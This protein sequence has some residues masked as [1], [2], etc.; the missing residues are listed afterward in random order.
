MPPSDGAT[1]TEY[2]FGKGGKWKNKKYRK[3]GGITKSTQRIQ[4]YKKYKLGD[5]YRWKATFA[6]AHRDKNNEYEMELDLR[7]DLWLGM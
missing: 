3:G 6:H 2:D 5:I 4:K 7:K 1:E